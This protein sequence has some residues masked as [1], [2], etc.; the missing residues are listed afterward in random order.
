MGKRDIVVLD[1]GTVVIG[2]GKFE[3]LDMKTLLG[4]CMSVE[5]VCQW[6]SVCCW[7]PVWCVECLVHG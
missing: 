5:R 6:E 2:G 1:R 7:E 4:T 3:L